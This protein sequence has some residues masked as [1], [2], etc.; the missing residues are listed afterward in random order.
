MLASNALPFLIVD[1][2][3]QLGQLWGEYLEL[4]GYAVSTCRSVSDVRARLA[5]GLRPTLAMID[6]SLPDGTGATILD[7]LEAVDAA[8]RVILSSGNEDRIPGAGGRRPPQAVPLEGARRPGDPP[9]RRMTVTVR[10]DAGAGW[11][12]TTPDTACRQCPGTQIDRPIASRRQ[13]PVTQTKSGPGRTECTVTS[14]AGATTILGAATVT[15]IGEASAGA[16]VSKPTKA[17]VAAATP[18]R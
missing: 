8:T 17:R 11:W 6:W 14:G 5:S 2:D 4:R 13:V 1:D 3:P 18:M 16:L 15:R 7:E 10:V 9:H 12:T